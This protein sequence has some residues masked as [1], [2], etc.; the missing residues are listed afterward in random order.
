MGSPFHFIDLTGQVEK[1]VTQSLALEPIDLSPRFAHAE[2]SWRSKPAK[3][4]VHAFRGETVRFARFVTIEGEGLEIGNVLCLPEKNQPLPIFGI[5]L[6]GLGG[7]TAVAVADLSPVDAGCTRPRFGAREVLPSGGVLP[8]WATRWF[9]SQPLFTRTTARDVPIISAQVHDY[10][11][12]FIALARAAEP[13]EADFTALHLGYCRDHRV[14]DRAL[15]MLGKMFGASYAAE[16]ISTVLFP[17][18]LA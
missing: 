16:L 8:G 5:D 7:E 3:V 2:G 17:E 15:S 18:V 1:S 13:T 11:E 9:S 12:A 14:E 4:T 6:V 10:A